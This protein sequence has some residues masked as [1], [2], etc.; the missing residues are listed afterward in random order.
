MG[1]L[2]FVWPYM[3]PMAP[4]EF[5]G[6]GNLSYISWN[7]QTPACSSEGRHRRHL[8]DHECSAN[9]GMGGPTSSRAT[10]IR[11]GGGGRSLARSLAASR[12]T[13]TRSLRRLPAKSFIGFPSSSAIC[14]FSAVV[15]IV[16]VRSSFC[17]TGVLSVLVAAAL[18]R[19]CGREWLVAGVCDIGVCCQKLDGC[20]NRICTR[21]GLG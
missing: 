1:T 20:R 16:K 19:S 9:R 18:D 14:A 8:V 11:S 10:Y 21:P 15:R 4:L 2:I 17:W 5:S 3:P 6:W 12:N 7:I 13:L